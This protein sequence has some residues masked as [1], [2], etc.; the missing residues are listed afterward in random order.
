MHGFWFVI[1]FHLA[2]MGSD[3]DQFVGNVC[4]EPKGLPVGEKCPVNKRVNLGITED[5]ELKVSSSFIIAKYFLNVN[6][7]N[8]YNINAN[9]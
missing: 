7:T 3:A 4:V 6:I 9:L 2:H 5:F 1:E 8:G